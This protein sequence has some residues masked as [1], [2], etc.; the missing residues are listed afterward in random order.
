M[1]APAVNAIQA[2]LACPRQFLAPGT[3][4]VGLGCPQPDTSWERGGFLPPSWAGAKGRGAGSEICRPASE[5]L[6]LSL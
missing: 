1:T 5:A 6:C 4:H 3:M 2:G